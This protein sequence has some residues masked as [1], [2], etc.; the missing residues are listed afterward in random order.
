MP[1]YYRDNNIR[2]GLC[3]R[4]GSVIVDYHLRLKVAVADTNMLAEILTNQTN[5]T[6]G[7]AEVDLSSITMSGEL[8]YFVMTRTLLRYC[9][10]LSMY[11]LV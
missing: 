2:C 10:T 7:G 9:D 3:N 1:Q 11:M 8:T 4:Q 6:I 5:I